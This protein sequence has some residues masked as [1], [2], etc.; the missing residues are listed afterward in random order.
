MQVN[1]IVVALLVYCLLGSSCESTFT[2]ISCIRDPHSKR[3][4]TSLYN[5]FM[6]KIQDLGGTV[7]LVVSSL[8]Y[9]KE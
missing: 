9:R 8:I 1:N 5:F 3:A 2:L 7:F 6:K 4:K